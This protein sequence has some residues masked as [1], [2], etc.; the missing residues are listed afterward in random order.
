[1]AYCEN[2]CG[3]C[4]LGSNN[5]ISH[6]CLIDNYSDHMPSVFGYMSEC[7]TSTWFLAIVG[8]IL[9][10]RLTSGTFHPIV[11]YLLA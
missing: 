3:V 7:I 11:L 10:D 6:Y 5:S 8:V 4:A 9:Q 2:T 1:M